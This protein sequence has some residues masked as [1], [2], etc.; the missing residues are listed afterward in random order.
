MLLDNRDERA[1]VLLADMEL[2]G[3]PIRI[4]VGERSLKNN[5]VECQVRREKEAKLLN[6]NEVLTFLK[7]SLG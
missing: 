5:Q 2:I 1:G 7:E 6:I 3:I 4:V